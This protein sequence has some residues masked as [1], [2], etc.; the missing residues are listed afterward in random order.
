MIIIYIHH[1]SGFMLKEW[2]ELCEKIIA[3]SN[4]VKQLT[5]KHETI[6]A[7]YIGQL[8]K[9]VWSGNFQQYSALHEVCTIVEN[10][11]DLCNRNSESIDA[12]QCMS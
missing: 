1:H 9:I 10:F 12:K 3:Q 6:H 8:C 2:Q 11:Q 4:S 5:A 7:V